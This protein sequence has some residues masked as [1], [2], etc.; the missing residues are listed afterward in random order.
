M[1]EPLRKRLPAG[2]PSRVQPRAGATVLARSVS[3]RTF[4]ASPKAGGRKR[5]TN[6]KSTVPPADGLGEPGTGRSS[7]LMRHGFRDA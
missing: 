3:S 1:D 5:T 6:A 4:S 2:P 7:E